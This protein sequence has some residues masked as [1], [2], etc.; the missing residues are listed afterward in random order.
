MT[1]NPPTATPS[2]KYA[3]IISDSGHT[4]A[5]AEPRLRDGIMIGQGSNRVCLSTTEIAR[6]M[7]AVSELKG[8][9]NKTVFSTATPA[10]ARMNRWVKP[11]EDADT[12]P[13]R[14]CANVTAPR[15]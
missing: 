10:K 12:A 14:L 7:D 1:Y 8:Y 9:A 4:I 6:L 15:D 13:M 5:W 3:V 11:R 2:S